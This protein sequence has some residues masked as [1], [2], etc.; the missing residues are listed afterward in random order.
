M[1]KVKVIGICGVSCNGKSAIANRLKQRL[2]DVR[3]LCFDDYYLSTKE[4]TDKNISWE[5]PYHFR[6]NQ[7]LKDLQELMAKTEGLIIAEGFLIFYDEEARDLFDLK[8]YLDLPEK[9]IVKRRVARKRGTE[10]DTLEYINDELLVGH[11]KFV[12]HQK[13]HVDLVIDATKPIEEI[14]KEILEVIKGIK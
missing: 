6:Y 3:L 10:S 7:Y 5:S 1:K 9:E 14:E 11:R 13:K 4:L 2:K 12:Y 8:I